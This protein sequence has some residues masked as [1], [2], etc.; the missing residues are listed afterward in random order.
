MAIGN[1]GK[2]IKISGQNVLIS[3][4]NKRLHVKEICG[5]YEGANRQNYSLAGLCLDWRPMAAPW[6]CFFIAVS[7]N[8]AG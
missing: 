8:F 7:N 6:T 5:N 1:G 3:L 2:M 4:Q